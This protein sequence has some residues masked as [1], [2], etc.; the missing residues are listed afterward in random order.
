MEKKYSE[1]HP[2]TPGRMIITLELKE[3][4]PIEANSKH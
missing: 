2:I 3:I 4:L 1:K